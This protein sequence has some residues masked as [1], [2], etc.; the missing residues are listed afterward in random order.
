LKITQ[1]QSRGRLDFFK[2]YVKAQ[3]QS[4]IFLDLPY[5][6]DQ[7]KNLGQQKFCLTQEAYDSLLSYLPKNFNKK[8]C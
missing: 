6:K 5:I 1:C 7:I 4:I 2:N 8:D 3:K